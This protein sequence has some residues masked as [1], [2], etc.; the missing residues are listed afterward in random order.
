MPKR[1]VSALERKRRAREDADETLMFPL[2]DGPAREDVDANANSCTVFDIAFNDVV[3]RH[4][5]V[6]KPLKRYIAELSLRHCRETYGVEL[7]TEY[8][9]PARKFIGATPPPPRLLHGA[10][11]APPTTEARTVGDAPSVSTL[12]IRSGIDHSVEFLG[13]PV[14]SIKVRVGVPRGKNARDVS[15]H[16]VREALTVDVTGLPSERIEL[17][18]M[19]DAERARGSCVDG[20]R[21]IEYIIEYLPYAVA[22][23]R[24]RASDDDRQ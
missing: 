17:P 5:E 18:F 22:V 7:D 8:R 16:V 9:L 2:S 4:A 13:H 10:P 3:V 14:T 20:G 12:K 19:L 11:T 24:A 23:A 15:V 1:V 21:T 6:Y